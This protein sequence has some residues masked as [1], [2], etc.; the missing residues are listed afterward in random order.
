MSNLSYK[1]AKAGAGINLRNLII[2]KLGVLGFAALVYFGHIQL[3]DRPS[4]AAEGTKAAEAKPADAKTADTTAADGKNAE[5]A[6]AVAKTDLAK[7]AAAAAA[8]AAK[9]EAEEEATTSRKSFLDD[10]LTLPSFDSTTSKKEELGK[11]LDLAEQKQR[12]VQERVAILERREK[13][14]KELEELVEGKVRS[15]ENERLMFQQSLQ[16]EKDV[17]DER[18]AGLVEYYKKME[19]KKAAPVFEKLDQDL[20]VKLFN[21]FP[22]KQVTQILMGMSVENAAK[23]T[24]YYGRVRSGKEYEMLKEMNQ[25][26]VEKF[27]QCKGLP[28]EPAKQAAAVTAPGKG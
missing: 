10:L 12:Q 4:F 22:Q 8:A 11:F 21:K 14:L 20:V 9:V 17:S 5:G 25:F 24:E 28:A 27:Q 19:A 2:L 6:N 7:P 23:L 15:L 26:L 3:G 1:M 18:L 13:Y 16:R